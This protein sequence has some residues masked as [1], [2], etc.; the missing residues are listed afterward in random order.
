[1]TSNLGCCYIVVDGFQMFSSF[2]KFFPEILKSNGFHPKSWLWGK[3]CMSL[4]MRVYSPF[5]GMRTSRQDWASDKEVDKEEK[6]LM[7][8]LE[9][10]IGPRFFEVQETQDS[11]SRLMVPRH[12]SH[13]LPDSFSYRPGEDEKIGPTDLSV[14]SR[15]WRWHPAVMCS[16]TVDIFL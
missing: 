2:H 1:M 15:N 14:C 13:F 6:A 9:Q 10:D 16:I 7:I 12:R 5:G 3:H 8:F 4:P 11:L